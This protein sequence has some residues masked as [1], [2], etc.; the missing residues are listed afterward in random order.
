LQHGSHILCGQGQC[1]IPLSSP[2]MLARAITRKSI[3]PRL[4]WGF[5]NNDCLTGWGC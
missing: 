2:L 1:H 4:L 5:R 3:Y